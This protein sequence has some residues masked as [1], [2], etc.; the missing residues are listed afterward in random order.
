MPWAIARETELVVAVWAYCLVGALVL[1]LRLALALALAIVDVG[2]GL[3]FTATALRG[4]VD[5]TLGVETGDVRWIGSEEI[6]CDC[7][8]PAVIRVSVASAE[9]GKRTYSSKRAFDMTF[10]KAEWSSA[11][12]H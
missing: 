11:I 10:F 1:D 6:L 9:C 12:S 2:L 4:E 8:I 7:R 3:V 5:A